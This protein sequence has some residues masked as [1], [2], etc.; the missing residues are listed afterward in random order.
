MKLCDKNSLVSCLLSLVSCLL[1]LVGDICAHWGNYIM[2]QAKVQT[3]VLRDFW[4]LNLSSLLFF[5]AY[6][7][8]FCNIGL[9]LK[10]EQHTGTF[11]KLP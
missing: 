3:D 8:L 2:F 5:P 6:A 11:C 7:V 4:F 1:S 9:K 10:Y